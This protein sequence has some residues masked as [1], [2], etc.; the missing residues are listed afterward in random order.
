MWRRICDPCSDLILFRLYL[1]RG[2]CV[3][4]YSSDS[5]ASQKLKKKQADCRICWSWV[6]RNVKGYK[7]VHVRNRCP[8]VW[9][10]SMYTVHVILNGSFLF[11][12]FNRF[13][14]Y[15]IYYCSWINCCASE[16][17]LNPVWYPLG[18]LWWQ[19]ERGMALTAIEWVF[20][21]RVAGCSGS[22]T[23]NIGVKCFV[24]NL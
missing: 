22:R 18:G 8:I 5:N 19:T 6:L 7:L 1:D 24:S 21:G 9:V 17:L 13:C 12:G 20:N 14:I 2:R 3:P 10:V 11:S 23:T 16:H 4:E 15:V